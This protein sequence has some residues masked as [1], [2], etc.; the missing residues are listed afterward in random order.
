MIIT[1]IQGGIG[2]QMFEYASGCGIAKKTGQD[3]RFD[4][5]GLNTAPGD[6]KRHYQLNIFNAPLK[7]A[8][9]EE[10]KRFTLEK[11]FPK[12]SALLK[13]IGMNIPS[14]VVEKNVNFNEKVF[15]LKGD[16]YLDGY[17]Q[18]E[19]YFKHIEDDIKK[20]F[21]LKNQSSEQARELI[22]SAKKENSVAVQ[23]RHGDYI[24]NPK[25]SALHGA[26]DKE[27]YQKAIAY[28]CT[29]IVNPVFFV[30][31]DDT[32]WVMQNIKTPGKMIR[33]PVA[34]YE[35]MEVMRW[36]KH[37]IISNSSFG[38]WGSWLSNGPNKIVIAPKK[39]FLGLDCDIDDRLPLEWIKI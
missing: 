8:S 13:K 21:I 6:T 31:S 2:N 4:L 5:S 22:K 12:I 11:R 24:T 17:W 26:L 34:D 3:L 37:H 1:R 9:Q 36:C 27:Y 33:V 39:W 14:Y 7:F 20:S 28:I 35:Q 32:N 30:I 15:S 10:L 18:S 23:V 38:W 29:K 25:T 19:K 16:V